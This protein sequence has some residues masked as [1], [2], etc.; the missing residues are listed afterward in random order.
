MFPLLATVTVLP[1]PHGWVGSAMEFE[2]V[3]LIVPG[4][5]SANMPVLRSLRWW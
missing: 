3:K 5:D 4:C 2:N 1:L